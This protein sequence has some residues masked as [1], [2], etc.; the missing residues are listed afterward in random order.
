MDCRPTRRQPP[1]PTV[2]IVACS[3]VSD[4][5]GHVSR[6]RK[7]LG[8]RPF[9]AML[10]ATGSIMFCTNPLEAQLD[11]CDDCL[12]LRLSTTYHPEK[13]GQGVGGGEM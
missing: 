12:Y 6:F 2:S 9:L 11:P 1:S 5:E 10:L 8:M 13:G 4:L 7:V 3:G